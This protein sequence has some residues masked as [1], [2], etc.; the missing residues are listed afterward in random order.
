MPDDTNADIK[1]ALEHISARAPYYAISERYYRGDHRLLFATEK[2][3]NAFGSLFQALSDN[4]CRT[5]VEALADRLQL[6]GVDVTAGPKELG[7][8][9]AAIFEANRM[10]Q[11]VGKVHTAALR[12][13]DAYVIVWP[14]ADGAVDIWPSK[15]DQMWVRYSHE[16]PSEIDLAAKLWTAGPGVRRLNLYYADRIEKYVSRK[17]ASTPDPKAGADAGMM[18]AEEAMDPAR[19]EPFEVAGE[20][21]PLGHEFGRVPVFHFANDAEIGSCGRSELDDVIPLQDALNKSICDML[22]AM[23]FNALSQR[24]AVGV[25][26]RIDEATGKAVSPF[27]VGPD[28][29]WLTENPDAKFGEF[30]ASD[31]AAFVAVS[32]SFEAKIA[33]VSGTPHHYLMLESG[34][35]PSG[36]SLKTAEARFVAKVRDRQVDFGNVWEDVALFALQVSGKAAAGLRLSA[37][38]QTPE[39]RSESEFWSTATLKRNAGVSFEQVA[40]EWGYSEEQ[41]AAMKKEAED[42]AN[43]AA[44]RQATAFAGGLVPGAGL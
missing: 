8:Q 3:R 28:R 2:F 6:R 36:E 35:W 7:E 37:T 38:W 19:F 25:E 17:A 14:G 11:R 33:R 16:R 15:A 5:V 29:L 20:P 9:V 21:W 40:R 30:S 13:G 31:L 4:L 10:D 32:N 26:L 41:I 1:A 44:E 18:L 27:E 43:A 42:D 22:V 34:S 24:W 39:P 12:D 23:E